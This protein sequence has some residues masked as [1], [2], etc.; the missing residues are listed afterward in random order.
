M[1]KDIKN[2]VIRLQGEDEAVKKRWLIALTSVS[3]VFVIVLWAFYLNL[4]V[5][6]VAAPENALVVQKP[7][8]F[9][10]FAAGFS[11]I[12]DKTTTGLANSFVY[13]SNKAKT[14][15]QLIVDRGSHSFVYKNLDELPVRP[16]P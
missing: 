14:K 13:F 6:S 4:T 15:N 10:I 12:G 16:L 11:V 7:G 9:G 3:V 5:I 1:L 2:F 8:F